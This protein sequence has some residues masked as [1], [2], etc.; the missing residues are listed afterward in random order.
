MESFDALEHS[1]N[2]ISSQLGS[3]KA[4][5]FK[6][7]AVVNISASDRAL[8]GYHGYKTWDSTWRYCSIWTGASSCVLNPHPRLI[9]SRLLVQK[10]AKL[11]S[12]KAVSVHTKSCF[13]STPTTC[14]NLTLTLF[15]HDAMRKTHRAAAHN[16]KNKNWLWMVV[17]QYSC[18]FG[19]KKKQQNI[20]GPLIWSWYFN[21]VIWLDCAI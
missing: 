21:N 6:T 3:L 18:M 5:H 4:R 13:F 7:W 12:L 15:S 2:F 9:K 17:N 11:C 14:H 1:V 8:M 10:V 16:W 19:E 20:C